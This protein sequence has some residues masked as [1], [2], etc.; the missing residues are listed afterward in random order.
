MISIVLALIVFILLFVV[1]YGRVDVF[2]TSQ[3]CQSQGGEC[4]SMCKDEELKVFAQGCKDPKDS[5]SNI[6][7]CC[8]PKKELGF[9]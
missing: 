7:P 2:S 8:V 4:R 3:T 9:K 6:G 5:D 1:F